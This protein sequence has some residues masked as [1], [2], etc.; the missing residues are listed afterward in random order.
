M[1]APSSLS[2]CEAETRVFMFTVNVCDHLQTR[3]LL[4][5]MSQ[6]D[7]YGLY[8][9]IMKRIM[10]FFTCFHSFYAIVMITFYSSTTEML[11]HDGNNSHMIA[12]FVNKPSFY[13]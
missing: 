10:Q 8:E 12:Q 2:F 5:E 3:V 4:L 9:A 6:R 1:A 13:L 7:Q 11:Q